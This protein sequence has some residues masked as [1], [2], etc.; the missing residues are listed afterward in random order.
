MLLGAACSSSAPATTAPA[1]ATGP[2]A[3][4]IWL[5]GSWVKSAGGTV[6]QEVWSRPVG[7]AMFGN[8]RSVRENK[9]VFFEF[10]LV[11]ATASGITYQAWPA[12]KAPTTFILKQLDG[13]SVTFENKAHDFPQ[14]IIYR[15]RD[16]IL[17]ARI[18]G[19]EAGKAK[20]S[21]WVWR[22][23]NNTHSK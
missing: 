19:V 14:R 10:L 13:T 7:G 6:S 12:G 16:D 3:K 15:R 4:L 2:L 5:S 21:E 17:H 20:F 8:N 1:P 18:E 22:R 23:D 11:R 9:L